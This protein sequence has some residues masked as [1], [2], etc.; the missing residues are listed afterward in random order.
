[1]NSQAPPGFVLGGVMYDGRGYTPPLSHHRQESPSPIVKVFIAGAFREGSGEAQKTRVA[2]PASG[3][4]VHF[5]W[6]R[7]SKW[8]RALP[9]QKSRLPSVLLASQARITFRRSLKFFLQVL[10][11]RAR[12]GPFSERPPLDRSPTSPLTP[13]LRRSSRGRVHGWPAPPHR[14][15]RGP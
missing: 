11:G 14:S 15:R 5:L 13:G 3:Y 6:V 10:S 8:G 2:L 1:M 7:G 12:E 4:R 9:G